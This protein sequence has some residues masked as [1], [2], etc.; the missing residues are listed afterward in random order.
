MPVMGVLVLYA[1]IGQKRRK[2][3]L[4][5]VSGG[6][7]DILGLHWMAEFTRLHIL[8]LMSPEKIDPSRVLTLLEEPLHPLLAAHPCVLVGND[9]TPMHLPLDEVHIFID[10]SAPPVRM[11]SRTLPLRVADLVRVELRSWWS[12]CC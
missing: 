2:V 7:E 8:S 6:T 10:P 12:C 5:V 3:R 1:K 9:R 4:Y 11:R